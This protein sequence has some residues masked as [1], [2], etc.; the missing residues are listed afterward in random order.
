MQ[1]AKYELKQNKIKRKTEEE[2]RHNEMKGKKLN[3]ITVHYADDV[4]DMV[5]TPVLDVERTYK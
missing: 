5:F 2:N 1:N 3:V 4:L